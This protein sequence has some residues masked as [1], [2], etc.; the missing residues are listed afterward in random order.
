MRGI[1]P[2]FP[3]FSRTALAAGAEEW[4]APYLAGMSNIKEAKALDVA[5]ILRGMLGHEQVRRLDR[6]LPG[7]LELPGGRVAVDYTGPTPK[8][9]ARAKVFY[10]LDETPKLAGGRVGLQ[11][12][13]L[14]PAGRP[15]AITADLAGF[16]RNGWKDARRDMRGRY[17]K[18]DWPEE[19]WV[20]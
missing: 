1:D 10:G 15:I 5:G 8:I 4:L 2:A 3:D 14:S 16:W 18:H 9:E 7:F 17:P 12:A 6:E 20:K 19:P 11:M 13:L